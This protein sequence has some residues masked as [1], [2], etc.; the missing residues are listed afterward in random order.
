MFDLS[1]LVDLSLGA[2][3]LAQL[4]GFRR[5]VRAY[6]TANDA[7]HESHEVRL[8]GLE[9]VTLVAGEPTLVGYRVK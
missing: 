8:D 5:D 1:A 3:A 9:A 4:R 2:A 6:M 7:R